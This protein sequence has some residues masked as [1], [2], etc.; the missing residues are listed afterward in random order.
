MITEY[1][2]TGITCGHCVNAIKTEVGAIPGVTQVE[3]DLDGALTIHSGS[4]INFSQLTAALTEAG[5]EYSA[6]AR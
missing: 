6:T 4:E 5:D 2:V 1:Q 3:L